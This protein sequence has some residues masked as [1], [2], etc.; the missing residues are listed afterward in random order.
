ML[1]SSCKSSLVSAITDANKFGIEVTK[2]LE[3]DDPNELE[4]ENLLS[5]LQVC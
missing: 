5:E 2:K 1:Y 3:I 4:L